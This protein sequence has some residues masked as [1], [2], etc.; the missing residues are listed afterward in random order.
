MAEECADRAVTLVKDDA[1]ILPVTAEKHRRILLQVLGGCASDAR[2]MKTF[3]EEFEKRGHTV[4]PYEKEVFDF[5]KP[6]PFDSAGSF[7]EKYDLVVYVGNVE[8]ASNKTVNR[9]SWYTLFGLGNNLPWFVK[10]VP[11]IFVSLQNPYH[12]IDVPMIGTYVNAYSNHDAMIR[13][14]TAKLHGE[15]DFI[16]VSPV[17]PF[18]GNDYIKGWTKA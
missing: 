10:E 8:N 14:V 9:I 3:A 1:K 17:Y 18:C 16:G 11:T 4:I 13:A 15:S 7:R 5:T 6:L 12:L 2:V